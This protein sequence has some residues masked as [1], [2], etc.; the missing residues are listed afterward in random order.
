[1]A[2]NGCVA[3]LFNGA[4]FAGEGLNF[5][6]LFMLPQSLKLVPDLCVWRKLSQLHTVWPKTSS[7]K[8]DKQRN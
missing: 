7:L 4:A 1:M 3:I 6:I 2:H 8:Y 5:F